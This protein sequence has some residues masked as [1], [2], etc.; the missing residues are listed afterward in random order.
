MYLLFSPNLF[1]AKC[2]NFLPYMGISL[3][4]KKKKTTY[5]ILKRGENIT[6]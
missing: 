3:K 1:F 5:S 6:D 2:L 4:K